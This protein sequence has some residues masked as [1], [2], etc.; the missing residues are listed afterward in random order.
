MQIRQEKPMVVNKRTNSVPVNKVLDYIQQAIANN[1]FMPGDRLPS[2]RKLSEQLEVGRPHVREAIQKMELYGI[3]RTYPQSG[4]VV[5][6]F[7]KAQMDSLVSE[8]LKVSK[9]DFYSLVYVRVLLEI[10]ACKLAARN[11]TIQDIDK[12]E[13]TL[14]DLEEC[15]EADLRVKKDFNF[16]QAVAKSG[17]N[18]VITALLGIIMPDIMKYYHK[19]RFCATPERIVCSEHREFLQKVKDCDEDGMKELVLRHL[20]N[21]IDFARKTRGEEIPDF[22]FEG[23]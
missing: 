14:H 12:I 16:H 3:L 19:Y 11:R 2:E 20:S 21:Q 7:T 18:P 10:E 23:F 22:N 13:R 1:D 5:A 15:G 9:Y 4:T 8:K 6:E 17:H